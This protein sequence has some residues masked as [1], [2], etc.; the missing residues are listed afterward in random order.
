MTVLSKQGILPWLPR[1]PSRAFTLR[2]FALRSPRIALSLR[3]NRPSCGPVRVGVHLDTPNYLRRLFAL[4][5]SGAYQPPRVVARDSRETK[6]ENGD[7]TNKSTYRQNATI[8]RQKTR[9][10]LSPKL[11]RTLEKPSVCAASETR[12]NTACLACVAPVTV[13]IHHA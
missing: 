13:E 4:R 5:D 8:T 12:I 7:G 6:N 11:S 10:E 9:Q 3:G 2:G 1:H